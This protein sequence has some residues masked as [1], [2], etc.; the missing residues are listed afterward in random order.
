MRNSRQFQLSVTLHTLSRCPAKEE[1]LSIAC[2]YSEIR[3]PKI[4]HDGIVN[5]NYFT[6]A[7]EQRAA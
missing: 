6:F 4:P 5:P 1:Y 3:S 2:W 7:I